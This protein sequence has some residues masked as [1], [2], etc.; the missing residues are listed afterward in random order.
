MSRLGFLRCFVRAVLWLL[1]ELESAPRLSV[2]ER[3]LKWVV[4][5]LFRLADPL[6]HGIEI[7]VSLQSSAFVCPASTGRPGFFSSQHSSPSEPK[8]EF[9]A[10][11]STQFGH[12]EQHDRS[13][14]EE[15]V[16]HTSEDHEDGGRVP[17]VV[18]S[19]AWVDEVKTLK[20]GDVYVGR[21]SKQRGL[22]P[23]FWANRYK[24]SK[25]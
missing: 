12:D 24:V 10:D 16:V 3:S 8:S 6:V 13:E 22:L 21:G 18:P 15:D 2:W 11:P 20:K 25:F 17:L 9:P 7:G 4:V 14:S 5:G 19:R 23:S 1:P